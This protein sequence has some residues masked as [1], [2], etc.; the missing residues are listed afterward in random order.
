MFSVSVADVDED[1]ASRRAARTRWR[2]TT[3][4]NE[5]M[6]TSSP[7]SI[8]ASSAAIS[9]AAVQDGVSSAAARRSAPRATA[10]SVAERAVAGELQALDRL[11]RCTRTRGRSRT[12]G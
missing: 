11:R 6:I 5:G 8:S 3:N 9:S 1:R 12:G 4:V 2:S 7:G 10:R